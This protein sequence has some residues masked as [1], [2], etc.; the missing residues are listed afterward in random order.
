MTQQFYVGQRVR[1]KDNCNSNRYGMIPG[2]RQ[3]LG[4]ETTIHT[5]QRY[6]GKWCLGFDIN[7]HYAWDES[8]VEILEAPVKLPKSALN[9]L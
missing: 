4:K 1:I 5:V 9:L 6:N 3:F 2:M 7:P 8:C